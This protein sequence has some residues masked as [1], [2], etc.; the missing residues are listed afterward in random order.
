MD[1]IKLDFQATYML[2]RNSVITTDTAV[3][4]Y[5][6]HRTIVKATGISDITF[7]LIDYE[8]Y[9]CMQVPAAVQ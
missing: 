9:C 4:F 3:L 7:L 8:S 5:T 2:S 1:N 6:E